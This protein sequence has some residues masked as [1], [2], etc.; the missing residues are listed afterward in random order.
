MDPDFRPFVI[1]APGERPGKPRALGTREGVGDRMRTAAFAELQAIQAFGWA[2]EHFQDAPEGLRASWR[3]Q[4]AD[5]TR[6]YEMIARRME[7]L[8]LPLTGRPVSTALWSSLMECATGRDFCIR[9]A[10]AEERGRQAG[11]KLMKHLEKTDPETAA[12]FAEIAADEVAHVAL[13]AIWF[14]WTPE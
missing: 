6:H 12:V 11:V 5:E 8:D 2:A 4:V 1:C 7:E 14:D 13:A 10:A 3:A 9:I